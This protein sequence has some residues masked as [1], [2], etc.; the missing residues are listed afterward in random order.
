MELTKANK[1]RI[2]PEY[3]ANQIAAGEVV[4]RPESVV[5]ELVEN[6]LDANAKTIAVII[7]KGGKQ[8]I[9][10]VDDGEG[11]SR[12]DLALSIRRHATSK[13]YTSEDLESILSYGFR[14][15][16]LASI[17]SVSNLEIRTKRENDEI[18][19]RL[20]AEPNREP[21]IEPI[22]MDKGTQVFARNLFFNIPARRKFLKSDLT[23]FRYISETLL[24][25]ALC[26]NDIRFVFYDEDSLVFD[27]HPSAL[28][29]RIRD[30]LGDLVYE[31]ALELDYE[32]N[33]VKIT[34]FIGQP[35]MAKAVRGDQYIYLNR[36]HI[37]S[38]ALS[39]AVL[40]AYEHLLDKQANP[41]FLINIELDPSRYDVNVHPQKH[42]VK[43][44][45]ER[46]IFNLVNNAV[47]QTLRQHNLAPSVSIQNNYEPF[48]K[49]GNE[50]KSESKGISIVNKLTGEIIEKEFSTTIHGKNYKV[51]PKQ[52]LKYRP[53]FD[54]NIQKNL[55][56]FFT[57]RLKKATE[58]EEVE[59]LEKKIFQVHNKYVIIET[60][61]GI[62]IIDQHA[63]HERILFE[64]LLRNVEEGEKQ[65][66]NLLF[67]ISIQ[68]NPIEFQALKEIREDLLQIGFQ[69][70]L[71]TNGEIELYAVPSALFNLSEEKILRELLQWY[72]ETGHL[73][74]TNFR[75]NLLA[76]ISCKSSIRTGESLSTEELQ[77]LVEEL[78]RC[79]IP[80][81]C[82]HGRPVV[83]E[84]TMEELDKTFCRNL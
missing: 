8:L 29:E 4:Q 50:I 64:K 20:I 7:H 18:G 28:K 40:L 79:E 34:G 67:P 68:L 61:K 84:L 49:V 23:E 56:N 62:L 24:K 72:L 30:L 12:E 3:I 26:R 52:N 59:E 70:E 66:Q 78:F 27:V 19:W 63:A 36:R 43:F 11:M 48:E 82:P 39:Y 71:F 76:T 73:E 75:E 65:I 5:K 35:H 9:H 44:E 53:S 45:D 31:S 80:Y 6:S 47:R 33:D 55:E 83:I 81:S 54:S 37:R 74:K 77:K 25:I 51:F 14:G 69:L 16:A 46:F 15:E 60:S 38:R 1:I 32:Y 58:Q 17:A 21:T 41:F 22:V 13:I 2:L 57:N 42:E 10:V